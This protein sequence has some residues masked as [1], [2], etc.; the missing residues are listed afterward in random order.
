MGWNCKVRGWRRC[1]IHC[2]PP[3]AP[4]DCIC[5]VGPS[6]FPYF[7]IRNSANNHCEEVEI[8]WENGPALGR[9][10]GVW[11]T[12]E[13]LSSAERPYWIQ[14]CYQSQSFPETVRYPRCLLSSGWWL[15]RCWHQEAICQPG[16]AGLDATILFLGLVSRELWG[17]IYIIFSPQRLHTQPF[18]VGPKG[19]MR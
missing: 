14:K 13:A 16:G 17:W 3:R 1:G 11:R 6:S 9:V 12:L 10:W 2:Q 18:G 4:K 19:P 8:W 15:H 7:F 5:L